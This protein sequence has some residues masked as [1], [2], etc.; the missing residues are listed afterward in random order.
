MLT[1]NLL[2]P[3]QQRDI[4]LEEARR[5]IRFFAAVA[6]LLLLIGIT[7]LAPSYLP[8]YFQ[9]RESERA[10]A[11]NE[12]TAGMADSENLRSNVDQINMLVSSIRERASRKPNATKIFESIFK[13]PQGI[14]ITSVLVNPDGSV[15][16]AGNAKTRTRLLDFEQSLRQ[17]EIFRAITF[18]LSNIVRESNINFI[19]QGTLKEKYVL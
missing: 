11:I 3:P 5:I 6:I 18:P 12:Q 17:A 9:R 2:P 16:I 8:I 15:S 1:T 13:A 19:L 14:S 4:R 7:L 10:L